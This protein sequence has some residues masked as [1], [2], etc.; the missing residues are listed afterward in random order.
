MQGRRLDEL[1]PGEY[2]ATRNR[3]HPVLL[4]GHW[5]EP[6][7]DELL[8][9]DTVH[10]LQVGEVRVGIRFDCW[11]SVVGSDERT[12]DRLRNRFWCGQNGESD[13]RQ[14]KLQHHF[15]HWVASLKF[16]QSA[17]LSFASLCRCYDLYYC[18]CLSSFWCVPKMWWHIWLFAYIPGLRSSFFPMSYFRLPF[19]I[20]F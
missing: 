20:T 17:F 15:V 7:L 8:K 4:E 2:H 5:Q 14:I 6:S 9:H 3:Q 18:L 13:W 12:N 19:V 11:E 1:N 16:I 10:Q